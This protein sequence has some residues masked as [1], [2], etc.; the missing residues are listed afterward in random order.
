MVLHEITCHD[1]RRAA[2]LP[3]GLL[4]ARQTSSLKH[5]EARGKQGLMEEAR[6]MTE[7]HCEDSYSRELEN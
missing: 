4:R 6:S 3:V 2:R 7:I 5:R 1:S